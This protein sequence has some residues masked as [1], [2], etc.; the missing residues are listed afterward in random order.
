MKKLLRL[1]FLL[2]IILIVALV[3]A[4][5]YIDSLAKTG[6][7][8][9]ATYALGVDTKL[10]KA[11]VG[12]LSGKFG[13]SG[14]QVAN[15]QGFKAPHFLALGDGSVAVSLGSLTGDKIEVPSFKLSNLDV[16]LEKVNDK[17]NYQ[18]I[19]DNLKKF[20]SKEEK[21]AE[22]AKDGKRYIVKE[23]VIENVVIH[24]D[25]LPIGGDLTKI[26]LK[27]P[28]ITLKDVGSDS[29]KGVLMGE[30][31]NVL[32]QAVLQAAVEK[33]AGIIPPD[34]LSGLDG[35]LKQLGG[36]GDMAGQLAAGA[37]SEVQKQVGGVMKDVTG[38]LDK[39]IGGATKDLGKGADDLLKGVGG[40]LDKDKKK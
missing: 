38:E 13:L 22:P 32:V 10:D 30:L 7:E 19:L 35:G 8:K 36:L 23:V 34:I 16:H 1:A 18:V 24:V 31:S 4:I 6:I 28:S 29:D 27:I 12:I 14:L 26:D 21:P 37:V 33:G 2:V 9:G 39:A 25:L 40:L 17:A 20:E 3:A 11:S 5:F 15:P